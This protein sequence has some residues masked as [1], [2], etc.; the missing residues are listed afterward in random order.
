MREGTGNPDT[1]T[2]L[3]AAES[4]LQDLKSNIKILGK[5]ATAAMSAVEAQQQR[6]TLQRLISLVKKLLT[7]YDKLLKSTSVRKSFDGVSS[8]LKVE[9][10]RAYHQRVL[11]ILDQLESEVCICIT[12]YTLV[13][14][15]ARQLS[16]YF[17]K[18]NSKLMH[19][20]IQ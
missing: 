11:Q 17:S 7:K 8:V 16:T 5:E 6:L 19:I 4:K 3:E 10:E 9:S 15:P 14:V 1:V 20:Y 12:M 13:W 18:S 2:K